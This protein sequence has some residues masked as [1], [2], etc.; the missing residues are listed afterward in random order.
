VGALG[1][2]G[3]C[4]KNKIEWEKKMEKKQIKSKNKATIP[5][6]EPYEHLVRVLKTNK[7]KNQ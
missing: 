4:C 2:P 3:A 7:N 5:L 1:A 6:G